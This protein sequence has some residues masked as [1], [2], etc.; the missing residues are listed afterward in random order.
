MLCHSEETYVR[1]IADLLLFGLHKNYYCYKHL[2]I[3]LNFEDI[4]GCYLFSE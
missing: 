3:D 1:L 2:F 4:H